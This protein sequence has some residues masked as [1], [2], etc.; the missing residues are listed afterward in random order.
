MSFSAQVKEE[1]L[2]LQKNK[3]RI[4]AVEISTILWLSGLIKKEIDGR[5]MLVFT[6]N[7]SLVRKCFTFL[8]K[9]FNMKFMIGCCAHSTTGKRSFYVATDTAGARRI[10]DA[11]LTKRCL[12]LQNDA[13]RSAFIRAAF[14]VCGSISDPNKDYHMEFVLKDEEKAF[15][16]Q[17]VLTGLGAASKYI[18]RKHYHVVYLKEGNRIT[19][20]LTRMGAY[21]AVLNMENIR[22]IRETRGKINRFVNCE[23]ANIV[24]AAD[25]GTKQYEDIILIERERGLDWLP[26]KLQEVAA[27]R[28]QYRDVSLQELCTYLERPISKSGLNHRFKKIAEI[29]EGLRS[30]G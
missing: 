3:G 8:K 6:E 12:R 18:L 14:V 22:V 15:Y 5:I 4:E 2:H 24:K 20:V 16:I 25:N 29:A 21:V 27:L 17:S 26:P 7:I 13:E 23:T 30:E 9:T 11:G 10:V 1:V 19:E 28:L